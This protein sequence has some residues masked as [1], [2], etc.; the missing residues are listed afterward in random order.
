MLKRMDWSKQSLSMRGYL[1][2]IVTSILVPVLLFAGVV[3]SRYYFSELAR[4]D[5]DLQSNARELVL[6]IDRDL[7]GQQ[8]TLQALSIARSL[9]IGILRASI[10]RLRKFENSLA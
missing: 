10:A 5:E 7:Q 2:L 4:I 3:F 1:V 8:F 6:T 9:P